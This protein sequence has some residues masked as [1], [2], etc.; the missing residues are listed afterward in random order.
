MRFQS[1]AIILASL[2]AQGLASPFSSGPDPSLVETHSE[3]AK[4]GSVHYYG[5]ATTSPVRRACWFNCPPDTC[6]TSAINCDNKNGGPN[7]VCQGL[8]NFLYDNPDQAIPKATHQV[9]WLA[10]TGKNCCV[11]WTK[12]IDSLKNTHL[13][14]TV[15]NSK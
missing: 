9:C 2:M 3:A 14:D 6:A 7:D 8:I 13:A 4:G 12:D 1:I 11:K 10:D 5:V 15:N